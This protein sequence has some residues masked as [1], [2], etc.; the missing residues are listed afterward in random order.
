MTLNAKLKV[1]REIE[2]VQAGFS[3]PLGSCIQFTTTC[4]ASFILSVV[5]CWQLTLVIMVSMPFIVLVLFFLQGGMNARLKDE[6][7]HL[8]TGSSILSDAVSLIHEVK[9]AQAEEQECEKFSRA[10][11]RAGSS[12]AAYVIKLALQLG[13]VRF[14]VLVMFV[15]GF[16]FGCFLVQRDITSAGNVILVFWSCLMAAS[17]FQSMAPFIASIIL[18]SRALVQLPPSP[19]RLEH[20]TPVPYCK[21]ADIDVRHVS[22]SYK[23]RV[24]LSDVNLFLP[25]GDTTFILGGSGSGKSTLALLLAGIY[26]PSE[27]IILF[28]DR[29]ISSFA[30]HDY[31]KYVSY[32][33]QTPFILKETLANNIAIGES[34]YPQSNLDDKVVLALLQAVVLGPLVSTLPEGIHSLIGDGHQSLSGG[35][36]QR[37]EIARALLH[38]APL[39]I[40]DEATS[41]L[42]TA[43]RSIVVNTIRKHRLNKTTVIITHDVTQLGDN[44]FAYVLKD[45]RVVEEG[46][47]R[48]LMRKHDGSFSQFVH[49]HQNFQSHPAS[50]SRGKFRQS[51]MQSRLSMYSTRESQ[52]FSLSSPTN[53]SD[54]LNNY[55]DSFGSTLHTNTYTATSPNSF[56]DIELAEKTLLPPRKLP[57]Q[58]TIKKVIGDYW[59]L[60]PSYTYAVPGFV[61]VAFSAFT[62]PV[63]SFLLAQ[64]I[65]SLL[66]SANPSSTA[67][68]WSLSMLGVAVF[69]GISTFTKVFLL[70][71]SAQIWITRRR[72]FLFTTVLKQNCTW[73]DQEG[74]NSSKITNGIINACGNVRDFPNKIFGN[75]LEAVT[76]L[77]VGIIWAFITGW[78]LSIVGMAVV[79]VLLLAIKLYSRIIH[80][81]ENK[82]TLALELFTMLLDEV[83]QK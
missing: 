72:N 62:T 68:V 2:D 79:P 19:G 32:V 77:L 60:S 13:L 51:V 15:Q 64:L 9:I 23:D 34:A 8:A 35:Q 78:K 55:N 71:T 59:T 5:Y 6:K 42:D 18:G 3:Q 80:K 17:S 76:V 36:R 47:R 58:V 39:L 38:D 28:N 24:A 57:K 21:T 22:Y 53:T 82:S 25:A 70:E 12:Y 30:P 1:S 83:S 4:I 26:S 65:T 31:H 50:P 69:D 81:W 66:Q 67:L 27:G 29:A 10:A 20:K 49:T 16:W 41:A 33:Q 63:F 75:I 45:G 74:G 14:I 37:V 56:T 43:T 44:D 48:H 54:S 73:F 52:F 11:Q 40:L 7:A 46:Y 61:A